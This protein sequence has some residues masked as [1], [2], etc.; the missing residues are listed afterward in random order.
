VWGAGSAARSRLKPRFIDVE[1]TEKAK[2]LKELLDKQKI[3]ESDTTVASE[4]LSSW[5][6]TGFLPKGLCALVY[7]YTLQNNIKTN[8]YIYIYIYIYLHDKDCPF[9]NPLRCTLGG[10]TGRTPEGDH[11]T[12]AQG[13]AKVTGYR[14]TGTMVRYSAANYSRVDNDVVSDILARHRDTWQDMEAET[15]NAV[16]DSIVAALQGM[17]EVKSLWSEFQ[18]FVAGLVKTFGIQR[19]TLCMELSATCLH[20]NMCFAFVHFLFLF[21]PITL[22]A[23]TS[24]KTIPRLKAACRKEARSL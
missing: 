23:G 16:V 14:G 6:G 1:G 15:L 9:I 21:R 8:I 7:T 18:E 12:Y 2:L 24:L 11:D 17:S 19:S 4:L 20:K 3:A 13:Q 10:L 22:Y 5:G